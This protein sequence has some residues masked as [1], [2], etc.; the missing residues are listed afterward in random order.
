LIILYAICKFIVG[1]FCESVICTVT[2]T[3]RYHPSF[4]KN[5]TNPPNLFPQNYLH[6]NV[7]V[8]EFCFVAKYFLLFWNP[9][10]YE[11]R[12]NNMPNNRKLAKK[13]CIADVKSWVGRCSFKKEDGCYGKKE[14]RG[15]PVLE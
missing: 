3:L 15:A 2:R 12:T 8:K 10:S 9:R 11:P 1:T 6:K 7:S 14:K 13:A 5:G 4:S